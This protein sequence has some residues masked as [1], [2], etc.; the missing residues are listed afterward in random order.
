MQIEQWNKIRKTPQFEKLII[1]N[2]TFD[3]SALPK[4]KIRRA[5]RQLKGF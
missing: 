3:H 4:K 1:S 2:K 5:N